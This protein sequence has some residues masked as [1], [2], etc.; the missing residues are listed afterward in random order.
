MSH[1][2][3]DGTGARFRYGCQH[4]AED[5]ATEAELENHTVFRHPRKATHPFRRVSV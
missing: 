5:F 4:C 1:G 3:Q 2:I